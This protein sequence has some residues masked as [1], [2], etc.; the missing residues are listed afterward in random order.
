MALASATAGAQSLPHEFEGMALP[1]PKPPRGESIQ[2]LEWRQLAMPVHESAMAALPE[3]D[4]RF[5]TL[6]EQGQWRQAL[7]MLKSGQVN[8][9]AHDARLGGALAAAASAG[10][11]ELVSALLEQ[12]ADPGLPGARGM[13]PLGGAAF[14]GQAL[15]VRLLIK[16]GARVDQWS[17][18]GESA[19]HLACMTGQ[20]QVID[21]LLRAGALP[22]A[23]DRHRLH[24]M[25]VAAQFGQIPVMAHLAQ[26]GMA[27]NTPDEFGLNALHAAAMGGQVATVEWLKGQGVHSTHVLTDVIISQL[28]DA[29][30]AGEAQR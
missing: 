18:S 10:E 8:P 17:A 9:N 6:V 11:I 5:L 22:S 26:A 13:T 1:A 21:E 3:S 27:L 29:P 20:L 7:Q 15:V 25:D 28:A 4:Q 24:A 14:A 30:Q 12:G 2:P 16:G 19:L 23:P